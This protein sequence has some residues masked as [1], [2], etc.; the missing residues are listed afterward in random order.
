MK[1]SVS[2]ISI[3]PLGLRSDALGMTLICIHI[4]IATGSFLYRCVMRLA[5]QRFFIRSC[6]YLRILIVSYLATFL[7]T[8]SLS[9][10]MCHKE[11]NQSINHSIN[12]STIT[13]DNPKYSATPSD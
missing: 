7:R 1:D 2:F 12:Q 13:G 10:L 9:V 8:N 5:S 11:V 4:F 3:Q 6:I